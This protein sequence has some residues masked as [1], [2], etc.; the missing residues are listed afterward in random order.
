MTR[1]RSIVWE[2][3]NPDLQNPFMKGTR[4]PIYRMVRF[5]PGTAAAPGE[6]K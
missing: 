6:A 2:F 4:A 3:F 5:P 1:K